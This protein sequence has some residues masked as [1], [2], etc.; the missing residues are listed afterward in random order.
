MILGDLHLAGEHYRQVP[1][2]VH[3]QAEAEDRTRALLGLAWLSFERNDLPAAEQRINE[4]LALR[5][6]LELASNEH[7]AL[8]HVLSCA[9]RGQRSAAMLQLAALLARLQSTSDQE[10]SELLPE[11]LILQARLQLTAGDH[12]AAQ[13]SIA[14]LT[15]EIRLPSFTQQ[16]RVKLLQA[17]L[18]FVQGKTDEAVAQLEHLQK[19][20]Q[21]KQYLHCQ[22]ESLVLLALAQAA[23]KQKGEA[24]RWLL[25]ALSQAHSEGFMRVFLAEGEPLAHLLRSLLPGIREK[26]L[27]FYGQAILRALTQPGETHTRAASQ[28]FEAL[29]PQEQRVL[30]FLVAGRTNAEIARELVISVNTVK[31]HV[32]H[33]YNKLG[34][35]NR[36]QAYEVAQ[37]LE[38]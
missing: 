37:R 18:Q 14:M 12:A 32:K 2:T 34:V 5:Q 29:S 6:T 9:T 25:Q 1:A 27:H 7:L 13:R 11:A 21:E 24:R 3:S 15:D 30:R 8:F 26:M 20:A 17:R 38:E 22:I 19:E 23:S 31:D 16:M 36:L 28:S 10:A 33:I 35:S 4:A